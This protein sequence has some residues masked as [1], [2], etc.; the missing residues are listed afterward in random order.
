MHSLVA[1]AVLGERRQEGP[2]HRGRSVHQ[3]SEVGKD[4]AYKAA[5]AVPSR[6]FSSICIAHTSL[7]CGKVCYF[8]G[9]SK[10][11]IILM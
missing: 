1:G 3:G 8:F 7:E 2:S 6:I 11:D 9:K 5:G 4:I 10:G